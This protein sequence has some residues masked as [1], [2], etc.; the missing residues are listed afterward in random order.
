MPKGSGVQPT[1]DQDRRKELQKIKDYKALVDSVNSQVS[2]HSNA[3]LFGL[4]ST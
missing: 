2:V 1:T 4:T 3:I